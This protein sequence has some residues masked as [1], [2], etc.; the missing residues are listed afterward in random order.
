MPGPNEPPRS[1]V[2]ILERVW[3]RLDRA[4]DE[5]SVHLSGLVGA[6]EAARSGTTLA[7][8]PPRLALVHPADRS[9][10]CAG[11]SRRWGSARCSATRRR[12]G[13]V[14]R[15]GT[16]GSRR[17]GPSW[18]EVPRPSR[19]GWSGPTRASRSRTRA[20]T[21]WPGPSGKAA[22]AC[23]STWPRTVPT[24]RT[25]GSAAAP[26]SS[27][28][29]RRHGLLG[30]RTL[31]VHGVHLAE[32]ELREAQD[33]GAWLVHCPRS[34][35]NNARGARAHGGLPASGPGHG[36][37]RPGHAGRGAGG[38][39]EDAR[40][41]PRR[42]SRRGLGHARR[43]APPRRRLLR[44][45]PRDAGE[46][47]PGRSRRPRLSTADAAHRRATWPATCSSASTAA[48]SARR[49]WPAASCCA[50]GGSTAVDEAA[51]FARARRAAEALWKRME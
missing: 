22:P 7:L 41:G 46:R 29:L 49:W 43:R 11:R 50:T 14:S 39:P 25:A 17:T 37:P 38:V 26:A 31:L 30:P 35:M 40:R 12:T 2:E 1:F 32:T 27:E 13:T 15:A 10:R 33:A 19:A 48:T 44:R 5:E 51:V 36:R 3:W 21:A 28:R 23:T 4:L 8:R 34:N 20:S 47:R 24:S 9:T 16:R 42:R 45:P 18:P 6:I